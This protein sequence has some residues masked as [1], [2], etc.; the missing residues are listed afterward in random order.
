M[1]HKALGAKLGAVASITLSLAL[2]G[3][4]PGARAARREFSAGFKCAYDA[5]HVEEIDNHYVVTGCDETATYVCWPRYGEGGE[6]CRRTDIDAHTTTE[7]WGP[8]PS[9]SA[10]SAPPQESPHTTPAPP[11][12]PETPLHPAE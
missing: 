12:P 7:T 1:R 5:T 3:C 2:L 10:A 4:G 6:K 9:A 11:T 8:T